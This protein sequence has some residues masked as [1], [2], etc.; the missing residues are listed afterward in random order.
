MKPLFWFFIIVFIASSTLSADEWHGISLPEE[1]HYRISYFALVA[2]HG[3]IKVERIGFEGRQAVKITG[4]VW[5]SKFFSLFYKIDDTVVSIIDAETLEPLWHSVDYHEGSFL[6]KA[7]YSFNFQKGECTSQ[8]GTVKIKEG[9]LEPLGALFFLRINELKK[10]ISV[11]KEVFDGK[12]VKEVMAVF[13]EE[14]KISTR[15]G[16]KD[17]LVIKPSMK[18]FRKEGITEVQEKISLYLQK[19]PPRVPYLVEGKLLIGSLKAKL[20]EINH[21]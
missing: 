4:K 12:T 14:K 15:F 3:S 20:I 2:G 7:E 16:K 21:S 19:D 5:S 8:K 11:K 1:T 9:I 18:N 13:S 10:G 17:T 6:R